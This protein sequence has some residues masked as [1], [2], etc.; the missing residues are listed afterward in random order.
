MDL[1]EIVMILSTL[2]ITTFFLHTV[3]I[4]SDSRYSGKQEYPFHC[5]CQGNGAVPGLWLCVFLFIVAYLC[6]EGRT[7]DFVSDISNLLL[8]LAELILV[9]KTDEASESRTNEG[10]C[11]QLHSSSTTWYVGIRLKGGG[12]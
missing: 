2:Q 8:A 11:N 10:V 1:L 7:V 5:V 9:G 6:Q 3:H 12:I 4:D